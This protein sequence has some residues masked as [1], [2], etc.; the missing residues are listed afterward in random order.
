MS[1]NPDSIPLDDGTASKVTVQL[2]DSKGR[3]VQEMGRTVN[4]T[5]SRGNL[6]IVQ[7]VTNAHGSGSVMLTSG[8]LRPGVVTVQSQGLHNGT[9]E[10]AFILTPLVIE[11]NK[12]ILSS[13]AQVLV[14]NW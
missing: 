5:S 7:V 6:S 12:W 11:F 3:W 1:V 13:G 14:G 9:G 2:V 10:V 4:L 8:E